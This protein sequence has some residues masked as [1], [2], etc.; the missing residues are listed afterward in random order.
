M[1]QVHVREDAMLIRGITWREQYK[2]GRVH[3]GYT[4]GA[5]C[6]GESM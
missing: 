3:G 2:S 4:R 5:P 1:N 6:A